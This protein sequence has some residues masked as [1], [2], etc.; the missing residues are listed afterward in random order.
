MKNKRWV[1]K[2]T[3]AKYN[4]GSGTYIYLYSLETAKNLYWG[5]VGSIEELC[6]PL[7]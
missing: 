2:K 6:C 4:L 1:S 7:G 5:G 3:S